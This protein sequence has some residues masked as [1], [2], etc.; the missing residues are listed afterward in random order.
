MFGVC[1]KK[2][3]NISCVTPEV[4]PLLRHLFSKQTTAPAVTLW[5]LF[6]MWDETDGGVAVW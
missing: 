3:R 2:Q 4:K 5:I 6:L 1:A